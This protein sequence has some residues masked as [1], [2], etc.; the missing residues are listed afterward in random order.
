MNATRDEKSQW[1][2][3]GIAAE[4]QAIVSARKARRSGY[5]GGLALGLASAA[6]GA[7]VTHKLFWRSEIE[8]VEEG[9][10]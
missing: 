1:F 3:D 10:R 2:R 5:W 6:A 7:W 9:E 8:T 4:R